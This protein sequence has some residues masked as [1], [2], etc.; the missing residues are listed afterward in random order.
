L[1]G[2]NA[3]TKYVYTTIEIGKLTLFVS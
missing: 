3:E 1:P 2:S